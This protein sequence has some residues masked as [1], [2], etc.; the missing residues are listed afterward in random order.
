MRNDMERLARGLMAALQQ[1][2]PTTQTV[3]LSSEGLFNHWWDFSESARS[4]LGALTEFFDVRLWVWFRDPISYVTRY[5]KQALINPK[6]ASA[7]VCYGSNMR[8]EELMDDPWFLRRLDY[9]GYVQDVEFYL[10][11]HVV[12]A[13]PY[14]A[15]VIPRALSKLGI[16][17]MDSDFERENISLGPAATKIL[18]VINRYQLSPAHKERAVK[19]IRGLEKRIAPHAVD[20]TLP[21]AM[22]RKVDELTS[23]GIRALEVR[24]GERFGSPRNRNF[25]D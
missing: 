19:W 11:A 7:P 17:D 23:A 3:M 8:I 25:P 18:R 10:G 12:E 4:I 6:S 20:E 14:A 1:L 5:Y 9:L 2:Q 24:Y 15:D 21:E 22:V 16:M 13:M